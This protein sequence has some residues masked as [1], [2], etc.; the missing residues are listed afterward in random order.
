M[1]ERG[2]IENRIV[3]HGEEAPDQLLANPLNWRIHGGT[4]QQ[5][6]TNVLKTV[7]IVQSVIVN[8][9]TGFLL[10]GHLRVAIAMRE[11]LE[12]IPVVYCD[13]SPEEEATILASFDPISALAGT[14]Q[15]KFQEILEAATAMD[16]QLREILVEQ[17]AAIQRLQEGAG[18]A[19]PPEQLLVIG[20]CRD[21]RQQQQAVRALKDL[22]IETR[23]KG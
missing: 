14:D 3:G 22:G 12:K 17:N 2:V 16:D 6:L 21:G 1:A 23:T 19:Q 13:L 7:G 4:Q 5:A 20:V 15:T 8:Q 9:R 10:D 11:G 18:E